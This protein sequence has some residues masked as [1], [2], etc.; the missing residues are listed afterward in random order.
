MHTRWTLCMLAVVGA[1]SARAGGQRR[2]LARPAP[3][4]AYAGDCVPP[5]CWMRSVGAPTIS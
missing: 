3:L 4:P 1:S 5:T 2:G